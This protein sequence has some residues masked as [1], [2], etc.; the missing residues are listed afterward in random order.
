MSN[1]QNYTA[2]LLLTPI[3]HEAARFGTCVERA[4]GS[5]PI[6][7]IGVLEIAIGVV[8]AEVVVNRALPGGRRAGAG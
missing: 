2:G 5:N 8:E 4:S 7:W 1:W 6:G 3:M